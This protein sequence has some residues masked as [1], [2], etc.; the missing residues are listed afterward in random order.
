M[1]EYIP[2]IYDITAA[3]INQ[4]LQLNNWTRDQNFKNKNMMAYYNN[5]D[6]W[7]HRIAIPAS[8]KYDDFYGVLD[9][10]L[11]TLAKSEERSKS[12]LIKDINTTFIDRMEFRVVS[13]ATSDGKIPIDYASDCIKG[14]KDLI[15]YTI[16]NEQ[17]PSPVC[18]RATEKAKSDLQNFKLA[19]T[20]KGSFVLNIETQEFT[21]YNELIPL[22]GLET[23]PLQHR[24]IERIGTAINQI[25]SIARDKCQITKVADIAY[26][27]GINA[28]M[29]EALL[30]LKPLSNDDKITTTFRYASSITHK[31][32]YVDSVEMRMNHFVI[33]DELAKIYRDKVV[34]IEATLTGVVRS[35]TKKD[36]AGEELREIKLCTV[37]EGKFRI[38]EIYLSDEQYRV[39]CDAHKDGLEI[40]ASGILDMSERQWILKNI[41]KLSIVDNK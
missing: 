3:S 33:I 24:V 4:Y 32:G 14:L 2:S 9:G 13:E 16:C 6:N 40:S 41:K 26:K 18:P 35:L 15:L 8:E 38:V 22:P 37:Y 29:C 7:P 31:T 39:A 12:E 30:K 36:D 23:S 5:S 34:T 10:V 21:G 11:E 20:E 27:E 17:S 28:N 1:K 25:D 19:Q